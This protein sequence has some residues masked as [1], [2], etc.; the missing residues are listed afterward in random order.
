M[1]SNEESEAPPPATEAQSTPPLAPPPA[2]EK[3][4]DNPELDLQKLQ[5]LPA[6][7]QELFLLTF[8]TDLTK[9][10]RKLEADD[11]TAQQFYLKKE[12][13]RIINLAAPQPSRVIR[14]N[15]G[16]CLAHVF[17]HG[18]RKLLFE[19]IC[20]I[21]PT[22]IGTIVL[23]DLMLTQ[24]MRDMVILLARPPEL[25]YVIAKSVLTATMGASPK[26]QTLIDLNFLGHLLRRLSFKELK[27]MC[28][29]MSSNKLQKFDYGPVK[30]LLIYKQLKPP[31][32]DL[33]DLNIS[34]WIIISA[35]N[36]ALS[37]PA[38]IDHLIS[39]TNP[40][41]VAKF[42]APGF[43]HADL[44]AGWEND[45]YVNFPILRYFEQLSYIPGEKDES[46][47]SAGPASG[48]RS[49]DLS[50]ILPPL[51]L[52]SRIVESSIN[53]TQAAVQ[54]QSASMVFPFNVRALMDEIAKNM[55]AM[56][57]DV[58]VNM[59]KALSGGANVQ[60]K[61]ADKVKLAESEPKKVVAND[62]MQEVT[63]IPGVE[64]REGAKSKDVGDESSVTTKASNGIVLPFVSGFQ[65][66]LQGSQSIGRNLND[67]INPN[68]M[69]RNLGGLGTLLSQ[70][71]RQQQ[72]QKQQQKQ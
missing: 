7:Q 46:R 23:T 22:E 55:R 41:P 18:D 50:A 17:T 47:R 26:Y 58:G 54:N 69:F 14:N 39:M 32:Y 8:V 13:F 34:N 68:D 45:K 56:I 49:L 21:L 3:R 61:P 42:E 35:A 2:D 62:E 15:L 4:S 1:S 19:T 24:P 59:K 71:Q 57:G 12:I 10:V 37:T 65:N 27:Q 28:Q 30:N 53:A 70:Q 64:S 48:A 72:S 51:T 63:Q 40:K 36:D 11:C 6:E 25:R 43:N 5:S 16:L 60:Q 33:S 67:M 38:V 44:F 52:P 66:L 9:Y 29:Q 31:V 20:P